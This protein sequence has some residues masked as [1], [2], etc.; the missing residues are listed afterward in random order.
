[1]TLSELREHW[2]ADAEILRR[3]GCE[4]AARLLESCAEELDHVLQTTENEALT[5]ADAARE[6][7]YTVAHLRALVSEGTLHDVADAGLVRVRRWA[8]PRKPGYRP[9]PGLRAA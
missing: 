8:L 9:A 2:R 3:R 7:G 1:M 4:E 5:L 6:S